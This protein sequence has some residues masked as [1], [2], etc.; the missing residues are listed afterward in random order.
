MCNKQSEISKILQRFKFYLLFI[1]LL[2]NTPFL[3]LPIA[4]C[5]LPIVFY[6]MGSNFIY[7]LFLSPLKLHF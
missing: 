3:N 1:F 5:K 4:Y 6:L 7:D 2:I